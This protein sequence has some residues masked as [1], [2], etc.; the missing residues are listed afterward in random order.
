MCT[1]SEKESKYINYE[2]GIAFSEY[3]YDELVSLLG[4]ENVVVK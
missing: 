1:V 4:K 3:I 2:S